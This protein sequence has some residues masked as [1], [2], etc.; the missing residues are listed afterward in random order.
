ME[1]NRI[2]GDFRFF[3]TSNGRKVILC[4]FVSVGNKGDNINTLDI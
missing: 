2:R 3:S 1:K 4:S